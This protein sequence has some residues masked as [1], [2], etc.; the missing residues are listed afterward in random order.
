MRALI[1]IT[2]TNRLNM[3]EEYRQIEIKEGSEEIVN[4][5]DNK[6][7]DIKEE[8]TGLISNNN[9]NKNKDK[10]ENKNKNGDEDKNNVNKC[11]KRNRC[12]LL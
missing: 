11:N 9:K 7:N 12:L 5:E 1:I 6:E 10:D 3:R 2:Y 8:L 4:K